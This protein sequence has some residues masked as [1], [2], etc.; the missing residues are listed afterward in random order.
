VL[1]LN[2]GIVAT[3]WVGAVAAAPTARRVAV[4]MPLE[5]VGHDPQSA[6][7]ADDDELTA[8]A[9]LDPVQGAVAPADLLV[10]DQLQGERVRQGVGELTEDLRLDQR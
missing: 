9:L 1:Q 2:Q 5:S 8:H 10:G 6:V 4:I 3:P 7:L